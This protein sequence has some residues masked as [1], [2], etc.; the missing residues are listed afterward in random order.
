ME[1]KDMIQD[2]LISL[3]QYRDYLKQNRIVV[4]KE[5]NVISC[6]N[7]DLPN[8][9]SYDKSNPDL[10]NSKSQTHK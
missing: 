6:T 10:T 5:L 9:Q 1:N 3:D 2:L 4:L 7:Y 8:I